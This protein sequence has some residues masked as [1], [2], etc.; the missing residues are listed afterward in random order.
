MSINAN[1]EKG[2]D[3][4]VDEFAV[5]TSFLSSVFAI[6]LWF[7]LILRFEAASNGISMIAYIPIVLQGSFKF[8]PFLPAI[9]KGTANGQSVNWCL[10]KFDLSAVSALGHALGQPTCTLQTVKVSTKT[11]KKLP[12]A[13]AK[14]F[15]RLLSSQPQYID[16]ILA[17]RASSVTDAEGA[18]T[19]DRDSSSMLHGAAL[20]QLLTMDALDEHE[21]KAQSQQTRARS[22]SKTISIGSDDFTKQPKSADVS[23]AILQPL[24]VFLLSLTEAQCRGIPLSALTAAEYVAPSIHLA[25]ADGCDDFAQRLARVV[26]EYRDVF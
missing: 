26:A 11:S 15:G 6:A 25:G 13:G 8:V 2:V 14:F 19:D 10:F 17:A 12:R 16:V 9:E 23:G 3:V 24:R 18:S 5:T 22:Q 21:H 4:G 20:E 1:E 7:G